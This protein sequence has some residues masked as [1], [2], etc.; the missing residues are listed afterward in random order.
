M[1]GLVRNMNTLIRRQ[2]ENKTT[3]KGADRNKT[4]K[5]P[6]GETKGGKTTNKRLKTND[7]KEKNLKCKK[8]DYKICKREM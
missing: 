8:G 4:C 1:S 5:K 6:T 3:T 7:K 2:N